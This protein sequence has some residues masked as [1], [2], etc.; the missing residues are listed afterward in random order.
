MPTIARRIS[1]SWLHEHTWERGVRRGGRRARTGWFGPAGEEG[2]RRRRGS[3]RRSGVMER[4][5][6]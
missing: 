5:E 1:K 3:S 4:E 6:S 2:V